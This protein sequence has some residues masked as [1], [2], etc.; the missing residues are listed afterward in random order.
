MNGQCSKSDS[1]E[2][3]SIYEELCS[4]LC[5]M[6]NNKGLVRKLYKGPVEFKISNEISVNVGDNLFITKNGKV[7]KKYVI[8]DQFYKYF[9]NAPDDHYSKESTVCFAWE[10][11]SSWNVQVEIWGIY[12]DRSVEKLWSMKGE[13]DSL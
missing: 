13:R 7:I 6:Y 12:F 8:Q 4:D 2:N 3:V 5:V 11:I 9:A 1:D 10:V